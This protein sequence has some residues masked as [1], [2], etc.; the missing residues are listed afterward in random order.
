MIQIL[1]LVLISLFKAEAKPLALIY[2]GPGSCPQESTSTGC[3]EAAAAVAELAGF[4]YKYVGPNEVLSKDLLKLAKVWIQPG[5]R[6]KT[7]QETMSLGLKKAIVDFVTDGGGYVGFCAGGFLAYEQFG[8]ETKDGPYRATGLGLISGKSS[9]YNFFDTE[10]TEEKPAKI[11]KTK[12]GTKEKWV[13]WELG[14]YFPAPRSKDSKNTEIIA[15]YTN[16][17]PIPAPIMS[18]KAKHGRGKVYITAVHP[19]APQDWR[20][21]YAI[22]DQDGEDFDLAVEMI[23]WSAKK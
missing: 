15:N 7:Q 22:S 17:L 11:I 2:K 3:S 10:I 8:W 12:W 16:S 18:L 20:K 19:E 23:Q 9:Y 5:G 21:Y 4:E 1:T 14:P 6:A 13:Y